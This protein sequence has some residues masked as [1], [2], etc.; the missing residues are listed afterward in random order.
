MTAHE[1]L[2]RER[3][4]LAWRCAAW[5]VALPAGCYDDAPPRQPSL[6][7]ANRDERLDAVR[8]AQ[9][10]YGARQGAGATPPK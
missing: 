4:R 5:F 9:Q 6:S 8:N 10:K 1:A 3:R 7:S 2:A